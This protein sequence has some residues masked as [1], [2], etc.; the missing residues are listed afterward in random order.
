MLRSYD[1]MGLQL[2]DEITHLDEYYL[3]NAE[4]KILQHHADE[5]ANIKLI[6]TN[7]VSWKIFILNS[8]MLI[9]SLTNHSCKE[10]CQFGVS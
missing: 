4:R 2:F 8:T 10:R 9:I 1:E 7:R 6:M 5:L 3:T